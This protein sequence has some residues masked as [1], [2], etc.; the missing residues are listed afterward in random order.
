MI[1]MNFYWN[2]AFPTKPKGIRQINIESSFPL[3]RV[4]ETTLLLYY[5]CDS[6]HFFYLPD[7]SAV[8]RRRDGAGRDVGQC[9]ADASVRSSSERGGNLNPAQC[10]PELSV[11][12]YYLKSDKQTRQ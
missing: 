6:F 12:S 1:F 10:W 7:E 3:R 4:D 2:N 5:Q 9:R 8:A 11:I